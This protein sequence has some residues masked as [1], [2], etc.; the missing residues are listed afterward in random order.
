MKRVQNDED[1]YL[2]DPAETMDLTELYGKEF[3]KRYNE[4]VEM[5][6]AGKLRDFAKVPAKEQYR[7]ILIV[8]Q[9][10]SH[11]WL[12]WKD[13]INV[14]ALN[15]NTGTIHH[16]NLCTEITLPQDAENTS[17][18]NLVSINLSAFLKDGEWDLGS[19]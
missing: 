18:C 2:F 17:V 12:T 11:P 5:A 15:N 16:S 4:Y 9:A 10:T 8:L 14:R 1:W 7:Q 19:P 3:S 6:E 13:T